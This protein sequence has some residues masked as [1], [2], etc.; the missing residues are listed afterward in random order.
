MNRRSFLAKLV[1]GIVALPVIS[2]LCAKPVTSFTPEQLTAAI[3]ERLSVEQSIYGY[4]VFVTGPEKP[5]ENL[6]PWLNTTDNKWNLHN[7]TK[8]EHFKLSDAEQAALERQ[9]D[10]WAKDI[11][12]SFARKVK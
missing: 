12:K 11:A 7:G 2:K 4:S 8:Y 1:A 10:E 3:A 9:T 5:T 6:G